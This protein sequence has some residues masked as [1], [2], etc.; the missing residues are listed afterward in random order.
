[1][2]L[3]TLII[4]NGEPLKIHWGRFHVAAMVIASALDTGEGPFADN[5]LEGI[6]GDCKEHHDVL[7]ISPDNVAALMN[8]QAISTTRM[9]MT[10]SYVLKHSYKFCD[11]AD[12]EE[13]ELLE[14]DELVAYRGL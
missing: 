2:P 13:F 5:T 9:G 4:R 3:N 11:V 14:G 1:M 7:G 6:Y 12:G 10:G 8:Y